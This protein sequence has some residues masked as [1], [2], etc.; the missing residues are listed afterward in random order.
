MPKGGARSGAGRKP[1]TLNRRTIDQ[2]RTIGEMAKEY[3]SEAIETLAS[4]MRDATKSAPARVSAATS[5][6]DRG[7]GKALATVEVGKPGDF[8]R[9]SD[10]E[11]ERFIAER[12][13][14]ASGSA[15]REGDQAGT[16][17]AGGR[18][19]PH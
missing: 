13:R 15:R 3:T 4:I 5:L 8:T 1:G 14:G 2:T 17:E 10:D 6:L 16:P 9:A 19:R 7:W 11:L 12:A 18:G